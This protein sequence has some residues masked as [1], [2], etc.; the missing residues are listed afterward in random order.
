MSI[1]KLRA[2]GVALIASI[3]LAACGGGSSDPEDVGF[4]D[5]TVGTV[6][7][8]LTDAPSDDYEKILLS[9]TG[10]IL[11][12]G[13]DSQQV[14]FEGDREIDLLNL[15]NYSEPVVF[16][17][18]KVGTYKKIRLYLADLE[19]VPIGGGPSIFPQ[20]PA[21]GKI[22]L[23]QATGFDVL[24]GRTVIV[25][26]D[27]DANKSI[28]VTGAGNSGRVNFRPVVFVNIFEGGS[29]NK[30]ARL[31][32]AVTGAPTAGGFVLCSID[33]PDHCVDIAT[34]G[35]TSFF[36]D[37]GSDADSS[38]VT[39]GAMAVA[40]G[41]YSTDPIVLNAIVVEVGGNT[42]QVSGE[43]ITAPADSKFLL[44]KADDSNINVETQD[45]TRYYDNEGTVDPAT[46]TLGAMVEVE[47]VQPEKAD[48]ADPDL[49]RAAL[50]FL[51]AEAP[52][53]RSGTIGEPIDADART[54]VLTPVEEGAGDINVCVADPARILFVDPENSTVEE[55]EFADLAVDQMVDVFGAMAEDDSCF[56]ASDVIVEVVAES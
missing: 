15:Q 27:I 17:Q 35:D 41:E 8:M 11:I 5:P 53:Q 56:E 12:G 38:V 31:E 21:D 13:D 51:L 33:A 16:G 25:E 20:L 29:P 9:V 55:K 22:D 26:I 24:P 6:S 52:E 42:E 3:S 4:L 32:G 19:L 39:D 36:D 34:N 47:G 54:F 48:A 7:L 30:L 10:A 46:V 50:V 1:Q 43:V 14:L 49:I 45:G 23:L 40:I 2:L 28:K 37:T 18:V 44:L